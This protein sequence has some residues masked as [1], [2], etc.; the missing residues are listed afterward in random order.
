MNDWNSGTIPYH[1]VPPKVH[2]SSIPS[3]PRI[4]EHIAVSTRGTE[5]ED[6]GSLVKSAADVG[7]AQYVSKFS[8]PFDLEGLFS[9]SDKAVLEAQ[10]E[11]D[12]EGA[13][14]EDIDADDGFVPDTEDQVSPARQNKRAHSPTP[15][16]ATTQSTY[17]PG[18]NGRRVKVPKPKR[19]RYNPNAP[20]VMDAMEKQTMAIANP[21]NRKRQRDEAK[22]KKKRGEDDM[23]LDDEELRFEAAIESRK[24]NFTATGG[25]FAMLA[26]A[27]VPL[28]V[29]EDEDL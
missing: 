29:D 3:V 27:D 2:T 18:S 24:F 17:E 13:S 19:T 14:M 28:P 22:A 1:T 20:I 23:V 9:L 15:S 4:P 12:S 11:L 16:I 8:Q 26:E 7:A 10:S 5:A 25:S 21:L 6:D